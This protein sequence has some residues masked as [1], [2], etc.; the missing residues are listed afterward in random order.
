MLLG[1][2]KWIVLPLVAVCAFG[3]TKHTRIDVQ[4]YTIDAEVNPRTQAIKA[5]AKIEFTPSE[6]GTELAFE[7][8]NAL[9]VSKAVDASGQTLTTTRNPQDFTVTVIPSFPLQ[10]GQATQISLTYDGKLSGSEESPISGIRFAALHPDFGYLLYPARWF[11]VNG[12]TTNRFAADLRITV[13]SEYKVIG[14][15]DVKT[16]PAPNSRTTYAFNY[17]KASFP[18]SIGIVKGD[19]VRIS[20]QGVN[21]GIFF[22]DAQAAEAK[23]YGDETG[24]I[25]TFLT[26]LYGLAPQVNLTVVETEDGAVNGYSAPGIV[27]LAPSSI[28]K[29][30]NTRVLANQLSRQWWGILVS[31]VNRNHLW[32]M[33]GPARYSE[34]LYQEHASG[35]SSTE[36][37]MRAT[38]IEALTVKDPPVLQAA[39]LEDYSP[40]YWALTAAKGAAILNMLRNVVGPDNFVKGLKAFIDT[41]AWKSV[42][43]EDFR[44]VFERVSNQELRYFFVQWLESSGS[45]EFKLDYTVFRTQKGFRVVGKVTQD[46]DTFR[47]PVDLRIETEGNPEDKRVEVTGTSSEFSVDTFGKPKK[48][49][50]DPSHVLLRLDPNIQISVAIRRGEQFEEVNDTPNALREFERAL[51]VNKNSSLAHYRIGE[52]FFKQ[53]NYQQAANEFRSAINGDLDPKWTEVW[54]H[55]NLGKIFDV[56][57]QRDRA[58]NEYKQAIRT[59]D[60]T[61]GAQEEAARY[62]TKAYERKNSET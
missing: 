62:S 49:T 24:K 47:M 2:L 27:F 56:T 50:L 59:R 45:P 33:N 4:K 26:G 41:Y 16:Q 28:T 42:S 22:R 40:E 30:V 52:L 9:T 37:D 21:A 3:Q 25:M 46:L 31:P 58:V 1:S 15:G 29:K 8:N 54:S 53:N 48:L 51:E 6:A 12:Y 14:S 10:K 36:T 19:P 32:L 43:S 35:S 23:A 39:R 7:L 38:Y 5:T 44:K 17:E 11:P 61:S 34:I 18:G 60:N 57:G 20:S 55:L 13:P